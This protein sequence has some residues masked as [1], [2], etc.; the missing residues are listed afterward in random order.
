MGGS[1]LNLEK[2][3]RRNVR[4]RFRSLTPGNANLPIGAGTEEQNANV[5]I[6][7]PRV[8]HPTSE[9]KFKLGHYQMGASLGRFS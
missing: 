5:E 1:F 7:V 6:G 3:A 8:C 2:W 4:L 9:L